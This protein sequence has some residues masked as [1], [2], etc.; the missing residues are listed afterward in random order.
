LHPMKA[1]RLTICTMMVSPAKPLLSF[2]LHSLCV[3]GLVCAVSRSGFKVHHGLF[4][5]KVEACL[6][7][8]P[9]LASQ[10]TIQFTTVMRGNLTI[11]NRAKQLLGPNTTTKCFNALDSYLNRCTR[12]RRVH[13]ESLRDLLVT[14]FEKTSFSLGLHVCVINLH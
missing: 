14:D 8:Q 9:C 7:H 1:L 5:T 2:I 11:L 10:P 3:E 12:E 13:G 4:F 6:H